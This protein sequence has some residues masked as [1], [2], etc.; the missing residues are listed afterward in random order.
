MP[1]PT[2]TSRPVRRGRAP[3]A[4]AGC[5]AVATVGVVALDQYLA[6][7]RRRESA[8]H[9]ADPSS[10]TPPELSPWRAR[11]LPVG[12]IAPAFTL[13]DARTGA[14]VSLEEYRGRPVVLLLSSFG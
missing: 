12:S 8:G 13:A 2:D 4:F 14:R 10:L 3:L 9:Y 7:E 6:A 5:L 1:T 11:P